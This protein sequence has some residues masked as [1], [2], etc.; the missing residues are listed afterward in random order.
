MN[1]ATQPLH[2]QFNQHNAT[3][4]KVTLSLTLCPVT[5]LTSHQSRNSNERAVKERQEDNQP[6]K[7]KTKITPTQS[8]DQ[9]RPQKLSDV[10]CADFCCTMWSQSIN[11]T[12]RQTDGQM[13][14]RHARSR[15]IIIII[16][17]EIVLKAHKLKIKN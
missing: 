9:I 7:T 2:M 10:T 6:D 15:I 13:D 4:D 14:G 1:Q 3:E 17:I 16:I 12:D 5:W 11:V 8:P